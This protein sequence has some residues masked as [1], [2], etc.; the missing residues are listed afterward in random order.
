MESDFDGFGWK[1]RSGFM[2][3]NRIIMLVYIYLLGTKF[4]DVF[5]LT[6]VEIWWVCGSLC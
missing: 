5:G 4:I 3:V 2:L 1:S 6:K